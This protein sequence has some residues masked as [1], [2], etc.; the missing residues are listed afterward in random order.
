MKLAKNSPLITFIPWLE[1]SEL[2][3]YL[4]NAQAYLFPSL[5]PFGIAA[6]EALAA[7]C[8]VIAYA[9][10]GSRDF[11]HADGP[12]KN[13]L[14]F[15]AQTPES[16]AGALKSFNPADFDRETIQNSAKSFS[17]DVFRQK[18]AALVA[19]TTKTAAATPAA[20][21]TPTKKPAKTPSEAKTTEGEPQ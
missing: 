17:P 14:L 3:V 9:E 2:A 10:G 13:G 1:T 4:Q 6:V 7:G 12:G 5:E 21:T 19:K 11:V 16:L 18:I 8:S 20:K 15:S